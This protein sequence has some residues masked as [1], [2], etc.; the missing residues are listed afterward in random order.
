M[1]A[2]NPYQSAHLDSR[3]RRRSLVVIASA[4]LGSIL[5]LVVLNVAVQPSRP[6][7]AIEIEIAPAASPVDSTTTTSVSALPVSTV[8]ATS[9]PPTTPPPT[10]VG[11]LPAAPVT[12]TPVVTPG[13]PPSTTPPPRWIPPDTPDF[14]LAVLLDGESLDVVA[15]LANGT[16]AYF[17]V[18]RPGSTACGGAVY[19]VEQGHEREPVGSARYLF[20]RGDGRWLVLA[21]TQGSE[22]RPE[23]LTIVDTFNDTA[24]VLPAAGWLYRWSTAAARF[25]LYDYLLGYFT[26]YDGPSATSVR[27]SVAP[28]FV[29]ELDERVG[30]RPDDRP[31]WIMGRI[32]FLAEGELVAHIQCLPDACPKKDSISGWFYVVD[33]RVNGESQRVPD[34]KAP[35]VSLYCGV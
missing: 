34:D 5:A 12:T 29:A 31:G 14:V 4:G 35:P 25:V 33:G 20:P 17:A 11:T 3:Q 23:T 26:L 1:D 28:S 19:R 13:G 22:C 16:K 7:P 21:T 24:R 6:A 10:F 27:L 9:V 2:T 30:P 15:P 8:S 18:S 32:A